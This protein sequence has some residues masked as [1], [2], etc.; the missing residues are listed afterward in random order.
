[1]ENKK[2]RYE[3]RG[4]K[5]GLLHGITNSLD[6]K[7]QIQNSAIETVKDMVIGAVGGGVA[8][9]MC[10]RAA[11]PLGAVV[12]GVGHYMGNRMA[13]AF[14]I[15]MMTSYVRVNSNKNV[16]GTEEQSMMDGVN[17]RLNDFKEQL[18]HKFFLDK[19]LPKK[20]ETKKTESTNGVGEVQYF[21]S[22][23]PNELEGA[24]DEL[25][26]SALERLERQI[27]ESGN[28]YAKQQMKGIEDEMGELDPTA[29]NF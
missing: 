23:A 6:T 24:S 15:G 4:E 1:M 29:A 13:T 12:T 7:G 8:G 17:E 28:Q 21:S 26:L 18:Y 22:A 14:G 20:Q 16:N 19:F 5:K 27:A 9:A 10:G 25:D 11:F 3:E 2:N